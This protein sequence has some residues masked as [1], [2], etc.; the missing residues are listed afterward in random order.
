MTLLL[1]STAKDLEGTS[2]SS[3][4]PAFLE[5]KDSIEEMRW[6]EFDRAVALFEQPEH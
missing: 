6:S 3:S 2:P 1:L 5:A 4:A